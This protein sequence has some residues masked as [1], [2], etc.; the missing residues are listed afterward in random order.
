[1]NSECFDSANVQIAEVKPSK[2]GEYLSYAVSYNGEPVPALDFVPLYTETERSVNFI[3]EILPHSSIKY[4]IDKKNAMQPIIRDRILTLGVGGWYYGFLPQTYSAFDDPLPEAYKDHFPN[5]KGGDGD[6]TDLILL[7]S[8]LDCSRYVGTGIVCGALK[9]IDQ[10]ELD[11]KI[12][13]VEPSCPK[14]GHCRSIE[15]LMAVDK[16]ALEQIAYYYMAYKVLDK[17]AV[18]GYL[19]IAKNGSDKF[20]DAEEAMDIIKMHNQNYKNMKA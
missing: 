19:A 7:K 11:H 12:I 20:A 2:T 18:N 6:P 15:D 8:D 1:M 17:K 9:L 10:G 3:I 16:Q 5:V 4:E 13:V 14:Y